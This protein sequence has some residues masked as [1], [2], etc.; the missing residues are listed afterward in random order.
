MIDN[1]RKTLVIIVPTY[2]E[3]DN[4]Y[5]YY[6]SITNSLEKINMIK[7]WDILFVDDGSSDSTL[8]KIKEL[9][10]NNAN[11]KFVSLS[12][13]FGKESSIY[14]GLNFAW[15]H[16]KPN[17]YILMD[18]DL[19]DP[20]ELLNTMFEKITSTNCDCVCTRRI[21]RKGEKKFRSW[22]SNL[23][24]K[25]INKISK[26]NIKNGTRDFRLMNN[27]YVKAILDC[28]EYNRF[29]K[30]ISNWVGFD[31][32]WVEYINIPRAQGN[33]KLSIWWLFK[34]SLEAIV[35]YTT[36]PLAAISGIGILLAIV[37]LIYL[38][39]IFIKAICFGDP[40]AGWPSLA[41]LVLFMGSLI[42]I[43]LGIL[44]LYFEKAYLELKNRPLYVIK[45]HNFDE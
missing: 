6:K 39:F 28:K 25:I 5:P 17:Y 9:S 1:D 8:D 11:I 34:Y 18:V 24:Y 23:F 43:A 29:F 3:E 2:N 10:R 40:V 13:N 32:E 12:R 38:I 37:S 31:V 45:E 35:A 14:A 4:I 30:G 15:K 16:I 7:S 36:W 21:N 19:Q 20:P 22:L 44:G 41:C 27:K 26:I 33:T 42:L